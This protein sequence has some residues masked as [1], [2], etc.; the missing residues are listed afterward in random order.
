MLSEFTIRDRVNDVVTN[1]M[2]NHGLA[3]PREHNDDL[4]AAG[5]NSMGMVTL[6]LAVESEFDI[7]FPVADLKPD[8]FRSIRSIE[9]LIDRL[10]RERPPNN[11]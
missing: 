3:P 1:V 2:G 10:Q 7:T 11:Q 6:M 9:A 8:N 5:L 4:F